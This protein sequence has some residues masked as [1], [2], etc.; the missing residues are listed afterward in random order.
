MTPGLPQEANRIA[1]RVGRVMNYGDGLY[2]GM[3]FG[4]MYAAAF[5]E[6]DPRKVV[7]MGLR[8]IPADSGYGKIIA[9]VLKWSAE[10]PTDWQKTWHLITEKWDRDDPCPDG[11]LD[12]FNID[13]RLNGAFVALGLLYGERRLRED[14]GGLRARGPGFRLQPVER[15]RHPRRDA[16]LRPDPGPME[17]RDPEAGRHA[18]SPTRG[19]RSTRSPRPR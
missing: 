11:A 3:F 17:E 14:A 12:D 13:A 16:G 6:S 18:S 19:T 15:R 4:G 10:N 9:D 8:S 2:G 1:D 7:E 5:F